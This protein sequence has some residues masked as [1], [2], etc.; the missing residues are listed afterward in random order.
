M[1]L[2]HLTD[3]GIEK[4]IFINPKTFHLTVIMLKLWNKKRVDAAAEVLQVKHE[5]VS[6][7]I[8]RV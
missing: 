1:Y 5:S 8:L 3:S 7:G 6:A 4:S 2:L